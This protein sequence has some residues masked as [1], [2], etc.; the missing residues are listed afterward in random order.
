MEKHRVSH[1]FGH[2]SWCFNFSESLKFGLSKGNTSSCVEIIGGYWHICN[3]KTY[4]RKINKIHID[5]W[6]KS[7]LLVWFSV[8][9]CLDISKLYIGFKV[10]QE[11]LGW[12]FLN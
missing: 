11:I 7:S 5:F 8:P 6:S 4:T 2:I 12:I 1:S 9:K 3:P 10:N